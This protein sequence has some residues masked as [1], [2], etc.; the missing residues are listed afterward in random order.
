ML[1]SDDFTQLKYIIREHNGVLLVRFSYMGQVLLTLK[2]EF[3]RLGPSLLFTSKLK[4]V[5]IRRASW[6]GILSVCGLRSMPSLNE[7]NVST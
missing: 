1:L 5:S 4:G 7:L 3:S 2:C 6:R